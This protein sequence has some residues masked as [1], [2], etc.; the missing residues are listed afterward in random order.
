[1][2]RHFVLDF[3]GTLIDTDTYWNWISGQ[4]LAFGCETEQVKDA[5]E[6]LF[7]LRY[8]VRQ[9][10]I[11]LGLSA[12]LV[13]EVTRRAHTF[14]GQSHAQLLFDDVAEFFKRTPSP[15]VSIL[16]FGDEEHQTTR[17]V[18]TGLQ[19]HVRDIYVA[20]PE[21]TKATVLQEMAD[22]VSLPLVFVDDDVGQLAQVY[23]SGLPLTLVRM[24]RPNQSKSA[25]EHD[26][27]HHAWRV[28]ESLDELE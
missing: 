19:S 6:R 3:D 16:T 17:V 4:F 11:D 23:D 28:I 26:L 27:D 21:R 2:S 25:V 20:S 5:A 7:P 22:R 14:V 15:R 18:A 9:H 24:R 13:E 1:M 10:A 8:S 12:D